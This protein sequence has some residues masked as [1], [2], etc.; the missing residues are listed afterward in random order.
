MDIFSLDK[1]KFI[2]FPG[3]LITMLGNVIFSFAT[4]LFLLEVTGKS[5]IFATNLILASLP[6]AIASPFLGI[7]VDFISKK[8]LIIVAD[9]LNALLML[10]IF[11]LWDKIDHIY[12]IYFGTVLSSFLTFFVFLAY[13]AGKPQLF[14]KEWLIKANTISTIVSSLCRILGPLIGGI[15]YSFTDIKYF[16]LINS[17]SFFI[18]MILECFL[19]F[20]KKEKR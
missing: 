6:L 15:V 4:G 11:I 16:I 20:S 3:L 9:L 17:I 7:V 5:S 19:C 12:L 13:D 8:L 2:F 1:N 10:F 14:P 18:S